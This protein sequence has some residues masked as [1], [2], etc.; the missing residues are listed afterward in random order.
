VEDALGYRR[1]IDIIADIL[2][3]VRGNAKKTQIMYRA[4]LSYAVMQKYLARLIKA[5]LIKF[6]SNSNNFTLTHKGLDYLE[7]YQKY[8]Y[9]NRRAEEHLDEVRKRQQLLT[10]FWSRD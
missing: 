8:F 9:S 10:A 6:D 4:N 7:E 1:K 3:V 5:S 2:K